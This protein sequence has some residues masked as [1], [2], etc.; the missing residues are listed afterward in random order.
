MKDPTLAD[1]IMMKDG[2]KWYAKFRVRRGAG[3]ETDTCEGIESHQR[4]W[5]RPDWADFLMKSGGVSITG[6]RIVRNK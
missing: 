5:G 4:D 1:S 6:F 3:N 2:R